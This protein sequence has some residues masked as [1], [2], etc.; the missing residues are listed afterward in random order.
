MCMLLADQ[1]Q[2]W[3][4]EVRTKETWLQGPLKTSCLHG[5]LPKFQDGDLT[6]YHQSHAILRHLRCSL[7]LYGKDQQGAALMDW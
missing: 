6:L 3:K 4:E 1:R 5:Q 2:S 7:M